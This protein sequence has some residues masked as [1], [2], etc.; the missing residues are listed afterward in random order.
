MSLFRACLLT[1]LLSLSS[2]LP[3]AESRPL[4]DKLPQNSIQ[5]AF[6]ILR[7]DY[8]RR[9][10]LSYEELN[11]A[12]LQG[13]LERLDFGAELVP[14]KSDENPLVPYVHAEFL[15]PDVAY[16]RPET[17][18]QG[19]G[20]LFETALKGIL[21]KKAKHLILDLRAGGKG[22]FEE[23][24]A[25]LQTFLPAGELM[26]KMKQLHSDDAELFISKGSPLWT[27]RVVVLID[28]ETGHAAEAVAAVLHA[29]G[30]TL[31][32]GEKTRGA[33]VRYS[34]VT[35][36]DHTILRYASAE[37]LLPDGTSRFK[38]G[39]E[40]TFN[41]VGNLKQKHLAFEGSRGKSHLPYVNDRV[42]PRFN[43]RALV[44]D[45]NPELDDYIRRS[46]GQSLPGDEGQTR[47]VVT[48]RAIDFILAGDFGSASKI[49]WQPKHNPAEG[50]VESI[51]KAV[52]ADPSA[53]NPD[54]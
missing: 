22:L 28:G 6:Q 37:M 30:R 18:T 5:S 48:Q 32:I 51:P 42:R 52:P 39:L 36:D 44:H 4:L 7:R 9:E 49:D 46:K 50:P 45:Q 35:L 47:D 53:T 12:A 43:E 8:I 14:A 25:V 3:A 26:F 15:A 40:P 21:E 23:A 1:P 11:R 41:I 34:D 33:T 16:L 54:Q 19:E 27:G 10:D 13:L 2:L 17:F 24:A 20:A 29:Q 38:V 31:L